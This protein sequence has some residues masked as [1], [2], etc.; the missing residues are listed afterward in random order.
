MSTTS[1]CLGVRGREI[2][3][4]SSET[5]RSETVKE[6]SSTSE[7]LSVRGRET[8]TKSSKTSRRSE[9]VINVYDIR[10]RGC[11]RKRNSNEIL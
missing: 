9:T 11:Q 1:A 6:M 3:T 10:G 2:V 4:K 7:C 8:V 5:S